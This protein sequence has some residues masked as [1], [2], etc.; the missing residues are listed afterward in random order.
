MNFR[1]FILDDNA[2]IDYTYLWDFVC[3]H[4]FPKQVNLV[5]FRESQI[6]MTNQIEILCPTNHYS[7]TIYNFKHQTLFVY[8]Q[9]NYFEPLLLFK[10]K[11]DEP[12]V[13]QF[14]FT[15]SDSSIKGDLKNTLQ[16]IRESL[17]KCQPYDDFNY[18]NTYVFK[19]N[20]NA[21]RIYEIFANNNISILKQVLNFNSQIIGLVIKYKNIDLFVP[22][23]P[24]NIFDND[25]EVVFIDEN[26]LWNEYSITRDLYNEI[27]KKYTVPFT[28]K[29]K[30][31]EDGL[32][33]GIITETNQFVALSK[34]SEDIYE[35]DLET[36]N[37]FNDIDIDTKT[38]LS[39]EEDKERVE[40]VKRI[41]LESNFFS[42]FRNNN[43]HNLFS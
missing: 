11:N 25:L 29:F 16:Q 43:L 3:K 19:N 27:S 22:T 32:I 31:K 5:I 7:N 37:D 34:P 13:K 20:L 12:K 23:N 36:I 33:I 2:I 38:I 18:K 42:A 15:I 26:G 1:D 28:P 10:S 35:N 41:K 9:R 24:S 8:Q 30:V 40:L 14:S 4:L 17:V 39:Q 6:D 21:K